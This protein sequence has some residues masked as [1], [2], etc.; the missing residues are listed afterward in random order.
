MIVSAYFYCERARWPTGI[1]E[2]LEYRDAAKVL[3]NISVRRDA[4]LGTKV[5][6]STEPTFQLRAPSFLN[7]KLL[8]MAA[9]Q[10]APQCVN[11]NVKLQGA[12]MHL[13]VDSDAM[14][15]V[16]GA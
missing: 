15:K 10:D 5:S 1:G 12:K 11:G 6:Y 9:R 3:P 2:M 4:I 13:D 14:G 7:D 8:I 16:S